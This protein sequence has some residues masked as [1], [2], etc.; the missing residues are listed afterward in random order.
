M[1]RTGS[2]HKLTSGQGTRRARCGESRTPGSGGGSR[3]TTGCNTGTAPGGLPHGNRLD[4]DQT[5][6]Q[7][8]RFVTRLLLRT[9][10]HYNLRQWRHWTNEFP[11]GDAGE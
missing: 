1:D 8:P 11:D 9:R 7:D 3:E 5:A 4:E 6:V 10:H 2:H